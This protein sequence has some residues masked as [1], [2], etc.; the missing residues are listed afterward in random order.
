M[1]PSL[2]YEEGART[3]LH[4]EEA[5]RWGKG[6]SRGG[7][8]TGSARRCQGRW[9]LRPCL[10]DGAGVSVD[11]VS[12]LRYVRKRACA[13]IPSVVASQTVART[14]ER[15]AQAR[16]S[17]SP[18]AQSMSFIPGSTMFRPAFLSS[19]ILT[20]R[21]FSKV[22]RK[23]QSKSSLPLDRRN[24]RPRGDLG[25]VSRNRGNGRGG[26]GRVSR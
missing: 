1:K 14:A 15:D 24:W 17:P 11:D 10:H 3:A 26:G 9:G 4:G 13:A 22:S 21:K 20:S 18:R 8:N 2:L 19:R 23:G 7:N 12:I 6:H 5:K 16:R 25:C